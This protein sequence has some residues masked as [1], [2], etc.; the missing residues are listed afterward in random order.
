LCAEKK[1]RTIHLLKQ[2]SKTS[3]VGRK[4]K[5]YE[6]FEPEMED[7]MNIQQESKPLDQVDNEQMVEDK[8]TSTI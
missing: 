6:V 3:V 1:G 5:R 2:C 4:R 7:K 8:Q